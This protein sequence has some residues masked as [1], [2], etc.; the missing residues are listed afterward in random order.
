[1]HAR[2]RRALL[3]V[4]AAV[5]LALTSCGGDGGDGVAD[6]AAAL[7]S[8]G[9]LL[10]EASSVRFTVDGSDLP[11]SGTVVVAAEGVA[12]PPDSFDGE[13]RI[14][15]GALPATIPVVSVDGRL[16]AQLPLTDGYEEITADDIDFGDPGALIDPEQ[17][18]SSLLTAGSDVTSAGQVRVDGDVYDQVES[19]L[20]G[21]T[22]D[23]ILAISD[24]GA[25]IQATWALDPESGRLRRATLTGA[26][27][28]G[29]EQ[30]YTVRLDDYDAPAEISAPTG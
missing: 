2:G 21:K 6:P 4:G 26:F 5:V 14:R 29:G 1:M 12:V 25:E 3:P 15:S 10:D 17:G 27:Y 16:W 23:R 13:I 7:E 30:T 20:P 11:D 8:A 18:V 19:V 9:Q 28:P 24:P 22:V